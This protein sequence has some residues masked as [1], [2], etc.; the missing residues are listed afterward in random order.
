MNRLA[1]PMVAMSLVLVAAPAAADVVEIPAVRDNTL[2]ES[3]DGSLSNGAGT[4]LFVG[5]TAQPNLRRGLIAFDVAGNVPPG[6]KITGVTLT[7]AQVM[8]IA[9]PQTVS[10]HRALENWGEGDSVASGQQGSGGASSTGDATWFHTFFDSDFWSTPGGDFSAT[11]SASLTVAGFG[12]YSWNSTG[13]IADVQLWLD[14]P[15]SNF[16]WGLVGNESTAVT[17]KT[18]STREADSNP[19]VLA[20]EFD[21]SGGNEVPATTA[22]GALA[23]A[24][25]LLTLATIALR[26]RSVS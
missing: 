21:P 24:L 15:A 4:R 13:M 6:A 20:I 19:P 1:I 9:G 7:L 23:L 12:N 16:G 14:D 3:Q 18:F 5:V 11:E 25:V 2:Y 26:R 17:T 10:L 8:T 22:W